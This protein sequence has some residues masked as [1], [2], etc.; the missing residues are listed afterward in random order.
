MTIPWSKLHNKWM[1]DPEYQK[2]YEELAPEFELA[3]QLIAA[4]ARLGLSQAEV[5]KRMGTTQSVIARIESGKQ[6]PSTRTLQR[7][8][9][10]T[11][12]KVKISLV[13]ADEHPMKKATS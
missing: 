6:K 4:R 1:E 7:F 9:D 3:Q 13:P 11:G 12:S 8:A 2:A 10:A 5:A